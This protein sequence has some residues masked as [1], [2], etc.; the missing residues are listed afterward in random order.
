MSFA[1]DLFI[2]LM[3]ETILG[4]FIYSTGSTILKIVTFGK[5]KSDITDYVSFKA[6]K[7]K[8]VYLICV[9]GFS[10]YVLLIGFV[11]YMSH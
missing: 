1:F 7:A 10:F 3:V 5:F 11:A 8:N 6:N 4:I 9:L 2:W